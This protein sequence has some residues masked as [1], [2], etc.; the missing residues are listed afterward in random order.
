[1]AYSWLANRCYRPNLVHWCC[2]TGRP[3]PHTQRR[4]SGSHRRSQIR[5]PHWALPCQIVPGS[6]S[7]Y[8]PPSYLV[9]LCLLRSVWPGV[10]NRLQYHKPP[11]RLARREAP[12]SAPPTRRYDRGFSF[13]YLLSP[14]LLENY[15]AVNNI[16]ATAYCR[17]AAPRRLFRRYP[18]LSA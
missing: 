5:R 12:K 3:M 4:V 13:L 9:I 2:C 10:V 17:P 15:P 8:P 6:A 16:K 1:M 7:S 18:G 14:L 11:T